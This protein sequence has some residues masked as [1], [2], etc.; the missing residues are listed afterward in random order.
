MARATCM[1]RSGWIRWNSPSERIAV[2]VEEEDCSAVMR[3]H[4]YLVFM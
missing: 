1:E 4:P 3:L 2:F